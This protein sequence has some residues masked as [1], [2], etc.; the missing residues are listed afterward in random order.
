MYRRIFQ[1]DFSLQKAPSLNPL[2]LG[3]A[4]VHQATHTKPFCLNPVS[5]K[6]DPT[7]LKLES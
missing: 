2:V 4:A 5:P 1:A 3:S 7:A 6:P